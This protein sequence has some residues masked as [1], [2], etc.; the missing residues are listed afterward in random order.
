M[1]PVADLDGSF[2]KDRVNINTYKDFEARPVKNEYDA[3]IPEGSDTIDVDIV[4]NAEAA[5][6]GFQD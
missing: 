3:S 2:V 5:G 1:V 4:C 6:K